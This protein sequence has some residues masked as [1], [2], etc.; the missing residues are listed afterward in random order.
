MDE[1]LNNVP[2]DEE[3]F[4]NDTIVLTDEDN[5]DTEFR[6]VDIFDLD[7]K[8]YFILIPTDKLESGEVVIVR[9]EGEEGNETF[10]GVE[11]E[12]ASK[13]FEAFR[14]RAKD[15]YDFVD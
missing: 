7:E 11:E 15:D 2:Q 14:E 12:E 13:V 5:V 10:I 4:D 3:D 1:E 8:T 9:M 6:I